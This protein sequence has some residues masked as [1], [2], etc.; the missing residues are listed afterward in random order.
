LRLAPDQRKLPRQ[1][2]PVDPAADEDSSI[3]D[4][5]EDGVTGMCGEETDVGKVVQGCSGARAAASVEGL[6]T[7][8]DENDASLVENGHDVVS[9]CD[10]SLG[11]SLMNQSL[12]VLV[13][14]RSLWRP[15]HATLRTI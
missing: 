11:C 9:G 4:G 14:L 8:D 15:A 3:C 1:A 5:L 7:F 12:R 6:Y 10:A 2:W 13:I